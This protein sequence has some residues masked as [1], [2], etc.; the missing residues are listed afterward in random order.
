M[1]SLIA[2]LVDNAIR[3]NVD[4]GQVEVLT[5][6]RSGSAVL[7]V[8]NTGP[9]VAPEDVARLFEPFRK[10]GADR[11]RSNDGSGLGLSIVRA[12]VDAHGAS[13]VVEPRS[14]G[15]LQVEVA[16]PASSRRESQAQE[17]ALSGSL[18]A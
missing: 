15:G 12:V 7:S 1:E 6:T 4:S 16:F 5:G 2:N 10:A 14:D 3:H 18:P 13:I 9:V 17:P 8:V 11:T